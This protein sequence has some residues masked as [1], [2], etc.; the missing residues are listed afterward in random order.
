MR[1]HLGLVLVLGVTLLLTTPSMSYTAQQPSLSSTGTRGPHTPPTLVG[2]DCPTVADALAFVVGTAQFQS[3]TNGGYSLTSSGVEVQGQICRAVLIFASGPTRL[4]SVEVIV[5]PA[6]MSVYFLARLPPANIQ[7]LSP[8]GNYAGYQAERCTGNLFGWCY[9][10]YGEI[11]ATDAQVTSEPIQWPGY[12][13]PTG[14]CAVAAWTGLSDTQNTQSGYLI[15]AG[16]AAT[17]QNLGNSLYFWY[18]ELPAAP[19]PISSGG[20]LTI[21]Y[22]DVNDVD[23]GHSAG[24]TSY[25]INFDNNDPHTACCLIITVTYSS[26][27]VPMWAYYIVEDPATPNSN[28]CSWSV[29]H[30]CELAEWSTA[31]PYNGWLL[32][33][34]STPIG[35]DTNGDNVVGSYIV[36]GC[37]N[38]AVPS[39][40]SGGSNGAS[41]FTVPWSS[42]AQQGYQC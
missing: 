36:Q 2:L 27:S 9:G 8:S 5:N 11:G 31:F 18:E 17:E 23:I 33:P 26:L 39:G 24:S 7:F 6:P 10:G 21:G 42:S 41:Y 1:L 30:I 29:A 20:C 38:N 3:A 37:V 13:N 12:S 28:T 34:G 35:F 14:C 4:G 19:Q 32:A 15:Q 22:G 25:N 16:F 40:T